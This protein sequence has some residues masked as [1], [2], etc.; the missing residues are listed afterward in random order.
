MLVLSRDIEG[1]IIIGDDITITV[2]DVKGT[3]IKLGFSA[4]TDIK[5]MRKEIYDKIAAEEVAG[6][7]ASSIKGDDV[8]SA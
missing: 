5:I 1:S 3:Q 4:P 7:S 6:D 8:R 2:L